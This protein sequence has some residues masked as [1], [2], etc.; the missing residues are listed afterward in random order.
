M[1]V[2]KILYDTNI[3]SAKTPYI[4]YKVYHINPSLFGYFR[5]LTDITGGLKKINIVRTD[6]GTSCLKPPI[7]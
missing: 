5:L 7:L 1:V 4:R 3:F 2:S 6:P